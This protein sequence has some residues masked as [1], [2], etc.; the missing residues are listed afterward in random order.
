MTRSMNAAERSFAAPRVFSDEHI[1]RWAAVYLAPDNHR[2]LRARGVLFETFLAAPAEIL[3]AL[4]R[5]R[6]YL[7]SC[8]LLP[9]QRDVQRRIDTERA[10]LELADCAVRQMAPESH[11]ADGRWTEK[12]RHHA[13]KRRARRAQQPREAT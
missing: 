13:Y 5:P 4:D 3:A 10:L 7:T 1:E 9:A 8:G 11:C 2:R 6:F 12:T